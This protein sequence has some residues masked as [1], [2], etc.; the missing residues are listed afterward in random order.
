MQRL[1]HMHARMAILAILLVAT[2]IADPYWG[3]RQNY[4]NFTSYSNISNDLVLSEYDF[5]PE[6][7]RAELESLY[8]KIT[9]PIEKISSVGLGLRYPE[10][11]VEKENVE[12]NVA[13]LNSTPKPY[14]FTQI[15][16]TSIQTSTVLSAEVSVS[17]KE[18]VASAPADIQALIEMYASHYGADPEKMVVIAKCES[19]FRPDA[20]SPS[21][22]YVGLYQFVSSTWVSNRNAMGL[23]PDPAL[24]ANAEESIKTAAFKMGRDG[25]GAWPVCGNI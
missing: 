13:D 19:G 11:E 15:A 16:S 5:L 24:R 6:D 1:L 4:V 10:S 7:A 18:P 22:V 25:Y 8:T 20:V 2:S 21:G 14:H 3:V 17:V 23:D 12:R 9:D